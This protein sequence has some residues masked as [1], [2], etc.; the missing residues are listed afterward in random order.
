MGEV[1]AKLS[2]RRE[3]QGCDLFLYD[4]GGKSRLSLQCTVFLKYITSVLL[5]EGGLR[6]ARR[7]SC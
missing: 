4:L 1:Q 3:D 7:N 2:A 6:P 5:E